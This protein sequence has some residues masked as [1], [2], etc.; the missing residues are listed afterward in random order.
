MNLEIRK[1][2]TTREI[3]LIISSSSSYPMWG[4]ALFI[5]SFCLQYRRAAKCSKDIKDI[6]K[7]KLR[8][9]VLTSKADF[10]GPLTVLSALPPEAQIVAVGA[11]LEDWKAQWDGIKDNKL[12]TKSSYSISGASYQISGDYFNANCLLIASASGSILG[13]ALCALPSLEWI[14][15]V[16][17]GLDHLVCPEFTNHGGKYI[18]TNGKGVFSSSLAEWTMFCCSYWYKQTHRFQANKH[19]HK[20]E[21]FQ[22]QELRGKTLGVVGYGDIGQAVAKLA[23]SYQM[24]V[25]GVRKRPEQSAGDPFIDAIH[26]MERLPDIL[27]QSDFLV[28]AAALTPAT[29]GM[30]GAKELSLCKDGQVL[31][32]VGRGKLIDEEALIHVLTNAAQADHDGKPY[33]GLRCAS[34]DVFACEPLPASSPFWDLPNVFISSHNAD[35]IPGYRHQS[36]QS[37]VN[38]CQRYLEFGPMALQNVVNAKEGY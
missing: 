34:L 33:H 6:Y 8:I 25:V 2:F 20:W 3:I 27:A 11:S 38:N 37:F 19:Q 30:I 32:N 5:T 10:E 12:D 16:F 15:G 31:I 18:V 28:V 22:V 1:H 17:A 24:K 26:G 14:Q 29:T 23:K 4:F 9:A 13:P 21:P 36:V 7:R 35:M